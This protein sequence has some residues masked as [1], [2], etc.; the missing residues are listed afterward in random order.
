LGSW[1]EHR[2]LQE[3]L[4]YERVGSPRADP[5]GPV[6]FSRPGGEAVPLRFD[7]DWA[8]AAYR[9]IP[10]ASVEGML[11]AQGGPVVAFAL[12]GPSGTGKGRPLAPIEVLRYIFLLIPPLGRIAAGLRA[13]RGSRAG[14]T[15]QEA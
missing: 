11:L 15:R 12:S 4:P 10:Q 13:Q 8:R 3:A 2:A 6:S 14:E 5:F 9:S 1:L 7:E